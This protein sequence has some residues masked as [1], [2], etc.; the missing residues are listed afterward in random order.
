[1]SPPDD[2]SAWIVASINPVPAGTDPALLVAGVRRAVREHSLYGVI[3]VAEAWT[4]IPKR[5]RDH[6][7]IQIMYGEMTV[8]D[9]NEGDKTE[10]L[11][12]RMESRDGGHLTLIDTI[13]RDG[14]AARLA[15]GMALKR[16][17]CLKLESYFEG[18]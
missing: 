16:E 1:M 10:A 3:M 5:A 9:L 17:Q 12:V 6:T 4:Y 13:V 2:M 15:D 8:S 7:S 18:G 11:M 14:S